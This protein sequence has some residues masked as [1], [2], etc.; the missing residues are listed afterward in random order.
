MNKMKLH[1]PILFGYNNQIWNAFTVFLQ[2]AQE[3]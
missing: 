1:M 3:E 2:E